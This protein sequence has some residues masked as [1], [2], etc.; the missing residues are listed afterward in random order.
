M[1]IIGEKINGS[2]PSVA[3]AIAGKDADF[4]RDLAKRQ[5]EV[6]ADFID[7]CAS[8]KDEIELQTMK[9]LIDLVQEVT[10]IPIAVDS[11][12]TLICA[13]ALKFC[14]K[15]GLINSVSLEGEKIA[16]VF[17]VIAD[18]KWQ[19]AALL[20]D[21]TGIPKTAEHRID[22][23]KKIMEEAKAYGIK[24]SR[25]H[26]DPLVE[27]LCTSEDGV[28]MMMDVIR[29]I[30]EIEPEIHVTGAVSNISFNLPYRKIV[31]MGFTVL[32]M[33]AGMDSAILDPLNRDLRGI[34]Y[35]TEAML[36]NDEYCM[37]YIEAFRDNIFGEQK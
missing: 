27:M 32:S 2:I 15:P 1:I 34:I 20:C 31:N 4:I 37:E 30:K 12:N 9:W 6:G 22:I 16:Q 19:C 25:L 17:P 21:D 3:K 35:A 18:T 36:G 7:V 26:I 13:E 14:N 8:V 11:P 5:A 29:E 28:Q 33:Q 23:F 24:P 10:E